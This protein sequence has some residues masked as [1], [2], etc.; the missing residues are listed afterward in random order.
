MDAET[1]VIKGRAM[2]R[3][4]ALAIGLGLLLPGQAYAHRI[5]QKQLHER[6]ARYSPCSMCRHNSAHRD[7]LEHD[8]NG[9]WYDPKTSRTVERTESTEP[10]HEPTPQIVVEAMLAVIRPSH[11]DTILDPGCGDGRVLTTAAGDY[12]C[13]SCVG[14]EINEEKANEARSRVAQLG[15]SDRVVIR[16]GDSRHDPL[17]AGCKV[18]VM[19]LYSDLIKELMPKFKAAHTIASY[20]QRLPVETQERYEMRG[21]EFYVWRR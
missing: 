7:G 11:T 19:Y 1:P 15:L 3:R 21:H 5:H 16:E 14:I 10:E 18:V 13:R 4:S 17:I 8:E 9:N 2:N 20:Q 12:G 6:C